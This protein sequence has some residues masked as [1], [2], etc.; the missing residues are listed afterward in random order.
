MSHAQDCGQGNGCGAVYHSGQP[1]L[2]K[3]K[4]RED[5]V[6]DETRQLPL[7]G[8]RVIEIGTMITAPL[9]EDSALKAHL[10]G[11]AAH[12]RLFTMGLLLLLVLRFSPRGLIPE[13]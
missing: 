2:S 11:S 12:M 10:L 6:M 1:A 4:Y 8:L 7:E 9:A 5:S 13:K 3:T